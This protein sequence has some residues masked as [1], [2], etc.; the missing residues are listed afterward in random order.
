MEM[1]QYLGEIAEL[2]R[3]A[4]SRLEAEQKIGELKA[5]MAISD[6]IPIRNWKNRRK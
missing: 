1:P 2:N 3:G 6:K 4:E 5:R